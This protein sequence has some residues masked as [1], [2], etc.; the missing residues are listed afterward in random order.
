V[1]AFPTVAI[2]ATAPDEVPRV[3]EALR[4]FSTQLP[5]S[6]GQEGRY[7]QPD[8]RDELYRLDAGDVLH[9]RFEG[10]PD[11]DGTV[12]VQADGSLEFPKFG[13]VAVRGMSLRDAIDSTRARVAIARN[14]ARIPPIG[15]IDLRLLQERDVRTYAVGDVLRSGE[16]LTPTAPTADFLLRVSGADV[17]ARDVFILRQRGEKFL[18]VPIDAARVE[19]LLERGDILVVR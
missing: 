13:A 7:T 18:R 16:F 10:A 5:A 3:I 2:Y 12:R 1:C 15:A 11:L 8:G 17:D 14:S 6:V 4:S 19:G 9:A